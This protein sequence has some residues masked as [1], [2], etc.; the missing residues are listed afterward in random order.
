MMRMSAL[1]TKLAALARP[2]FGSTAIHSL[3]L[4]ALCAAYLQSRLNKLADFPGAI[5]E[6]NHFGS[7]PPRSSLS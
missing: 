4:L 7:P 2:V 3:A 1:G 6:M 5:A